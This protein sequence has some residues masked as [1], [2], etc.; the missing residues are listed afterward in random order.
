MSDATKQKPA[1]QIEFEICPEC[2][3]YREDGHWTLALDC[4]SCEGKGIR[5]KPGTTLCNQCGGL[6]RDAPPKCSPDEAFE[7]SVSAGFD[8]WHLL[9][10]TTY[11]YSM[12]EECLRKLFQNFA[13]KP[14]CRSYIHGEEVDFSVD[15]ARYQD[16]L[17]TKSG[18]KAAKLK[19]GLCNYNAACTA[20]ARWAH[21]MDELRGEAL[22]DEHKVAISQDCSMFIPIQDPISFPW[23]PKR[24]QAQQDQIIFGFL[25]ENCHKAD[26]I[27]YFDIAPAIMLDWA[28]ATI[29]DYRK[30]QVHSA[31]WVPR[32]A[33]VTWPKDTFSFDATNG[34]FRY[35]HMGDVLYFGTIPQRVVQ[36]NNVRA[37][38]WTPNVTKLFELEETSSKDGE[39]ELSTIMERFRSGISESPFGSC[40]LSRR[41]DGYGSLSTRACHGDVWQQRFRR[42]HQ[43]RRQHRR[44]RRR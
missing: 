7:I 21:V 32:G 28:K 11:T 25:Q 1:N 34:V 27:T 3:Q 23:D 10:G 6:L 30:I 39:N 20:A 9:D 36:M 29:P 42:R 12:C 14:R 16:R 2:L 15:E 5:R 33:S 38:D 13:I 26:A 37:F 44:S 18:G 17:W 40:R 41:A 35:A 24:T 43:K 4:R 22:C 31:L 8:S 19:Q